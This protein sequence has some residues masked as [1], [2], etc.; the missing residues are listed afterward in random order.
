MRNAIPKNDE[1]EEAEKERNDDS[2][3]D[4]EGGN[5]SAVVEH[6]ERNLVGQSIDVPP[7]TNDVTSGTADVTAAAAAAGTIN[8]YLSA[9]S[10]WYQ[11]D[12]PT[13]SRPRQSGMYRKYN[14]DLL[15]ILYIV[16][17]GRST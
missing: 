14:K 5:D 7:T 17:A 16:V 12:R 15:L 10:R 11:E 4:S 2:Q 6:E 9:S 8:P 3:Q 1:K 13:R